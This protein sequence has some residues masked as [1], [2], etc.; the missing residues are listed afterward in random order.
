MRSLVKSENVSWS[1][2]KKQGASFWK[3]WRSKFESGNIPIT[4]V[5]G[6]SEANTIAEQFV[7]HF[8]GA[9]L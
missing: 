5:N 2:L 6:V 8:S 7:C 4:H 9:W 1:R 3:C